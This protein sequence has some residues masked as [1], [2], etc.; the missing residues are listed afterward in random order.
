ML[1]DLTVLLNIM[2]LGQSLILASLLWWRRG[3]LQFSNRFLA[4]V[5]FCFAIVMVN[6]IVNLSTYKMPF[7]QYELFTNASILLIGPS[8]FLYVRYRI[9]KPTRINWKIHYLPFC[10]Y[11]FVLIGLLLVGSKYKEWLHSWEQ[12]GLSYF[13]LQ[14]GYYLF[15]CYQKLTAAARFPFPSTND[16]SKPLSW[17][18]YLFY[19]ISIAW[20]I[21]LFFHLYEHFIQ[22]LP[23]I[24]TLNVSLIF[25]LIV[26]QLAYRSYTLPQLPIQS[27]SKYQVDLT[28]FTLKE[29]EQKLLQALKEEQLYLNPSLS[30]HDLAQ[31][32][33]LPARQLSHY[34]N[35][36]KNQTFFDYINNF[37][38]MHFKALLHS[39]KSDQYT[40]QALAEQSGFRSTS[41]AYGAFKKRVGVTPARFKKEKS[42]DTDA[43]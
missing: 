25:V 22:H 31:T 15:L 13:Y 11:T 18:K 14:F 17:M 5:L 6:T 28:D 10:I 12:I 7:Q 23:D 37:R 29:I 26:G 1:K 33:K 2:G 34:L 3:Q 20:L 27:H 30:L 36:Y 35:Q 16:H 43:N 24:L 4:I 40:I 42:E 38:V 41:T 39:S 8:L 21:A 19:A 32:C 9:A